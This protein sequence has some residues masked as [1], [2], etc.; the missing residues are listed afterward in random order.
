MVLISA[1]Y[2]LLAKLSGQ[3]DIVIGTDLANRTTIETER[4]IGFFVNVLPIRGR[5]SGDQTFTEFFGDMRESMLDAFAHQETPFDKLVQE[6]QPERSKRHNPL[7]QAL[8]VMQNAPR[9]VL[10]LP[11]LETSSIPSRFKARFDLSLF[12]TPGQTM[13]TSWMYNTALF[14]PATV[15][16]FAS[17]YR[18]LVSFL[19][20]D[21]E[22]TF[23]AALE[24]L[25]TRERVETQRSQS[26]LKGSSAGKLKTSRRRSTAER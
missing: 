21:P 24:R 20:E 15:E 2:W 26:E 18:E 16:R 17:L 23:G 8:F 19:I 25:N 6:L 22:T 13:Q 3:R 5:I 12:V 4:L 1:F 9:H 11:G 7:V 10:E 14:D